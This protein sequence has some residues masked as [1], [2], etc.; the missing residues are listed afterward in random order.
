M[1]IITV[2]HFKSKIF[3]LIYSVL[4]F[5]ATIFGLELMYREAEIPIEVVS[6]TKIQYENETEEKIVPT[7]QS[8]PEE[9]VQPKQETQKIT[10]QEY[11]NM[12]REIKGYKVIGKLEIPKIELST[13]ILSETNDKSLN[14]SVTKLIGPNINREGNFCITGHNY[15]NNRMFGKLKKLELG[16]KIILTDT[17]NRSVTYTVSSIDKIGTKEVEVLS[18]NTM[19]EREVTLITC[20]TGALK[21]IVVKA[22]E[23]YD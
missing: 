2:S 22:I 6:D 12:P 3:L 15:N 19:G 17:Y 20:T 8:T 21:R 18:Q 16:D 13:Y 4:L 7:S 14:V 9:K 10:I 1:K 5:V 23:E 11:Q